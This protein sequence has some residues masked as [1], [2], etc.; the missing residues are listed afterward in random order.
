MNKYQIWAIIG[1]VIV[2]AIPIMLNIFFFNDKTSPP[3]E[4][5]AEE[6]NN[7]GGDNGN[8][9]GNQ[10]GSDQDNQ[11]EK[12]IYWGV[13][14]ASNANDGLYQCVR[15]NFGQPEVWGRYLSDIEGISVG[16]NADE[17]QFLHDN[18]VQILVIH[19]QLDDATGYDQGVEEAQQAIS[20]AEDIGVPEGV[21]LFVDIE[22]SFPVDSA[23]MEGWFDTLNDSSYESGM[24]GV[25][26]EGSAIL[27]A[28]NAAD[29]QM[30]EN[31]IVWSAFPQAE[32]TT[33]ENAPEYNPQGP[34]DAKLY[35]W[36]Y[37]IEAEQ[38][39]IDTNLFQNEMLDYLW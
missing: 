39:T 14:S 24:Y 12:E 6:E 33:K 20:L 37:A 2:I 36:Q 16:L 11:D 3:E 18:N 32:I 30:R 10:N 35:G 31:T 27:E 1:L 8:E 19:N 23:F 34:D 17:A 22:P 38:C 25:F 21:A 28:Y 29:Q 15:D 7:N 13:D 4:P 9:N 26:D 5:P